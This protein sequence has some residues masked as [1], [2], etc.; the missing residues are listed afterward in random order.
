MSDGGTVTTGGGPLMEERVRVKQGRRAPSLFSGYSANRPVTGSTDVSSASGGMSE[1]GTVAVEGR[2]AGDVSAGYHEESRNGIGEGESLGSTTPPVDDSQG[3]CSERR[4]HIDRGVCTDSRGRH[5][6]GGVRRG[7]R[8]IE[9]IDRGGWVPGAGPE[10]HRWRGTAGR[11]GQEHIDRGGCDFEP[12]RK[13]FDR[14]VSQCRSGVQNH[15][16]RRCSRFLDG[17]RRPP[18]NA[19]TNAPTIG[20][21]FAVWRVFAGMTLRQGFRVVG[22][23]RGASP[24]SREQS[25]VV[26]RSPSVG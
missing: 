23:R 20:F 18:P 5:I 25:L 14:G 22:R 11:A 8:P 17:G 12:V 1:W 2:G 3:Y 9:H 13:H 16:T 15:W 24:A 6:D 21:E 10:T 26:R 4:P 7:T 19:E